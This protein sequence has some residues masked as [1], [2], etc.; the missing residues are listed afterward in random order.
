[1]KNTFA[2]LSAIALIT[3]AAFSSQASL[4][5]PDVAGSVTVIV[6][7]SANETVIAID[8]LGFPISIDA[9]GNT[10]DLE[11]EQTSPNFAFASA[12]A[13]DEGQFNLSTGAYGDAN[14]FST[15]VQTYELDTGNGGDFLFDFEIQRGSL[16]ASCTGGP[17]DITPID[18]EGERDNFEDFEI[19]RVQDF[20]AITEANPV[21]GFSFAESFYD[22]NISFTSA[23]DAN[24]N[25][26]LFDSSVRLT[27]DMDGSRVVESDS[28]IGSL[29]NN[30]QGLSGIQYNIQQQLKRIELDDLLANDTVTIVYEVNMS[31]SAVPDLAIFR[32]VEDDFPFFVNPTALAQFGDPSGIIGPNSPSTSLTRVSAP[33]N[34]LI[35]GLGVFALAFARK[36]SAK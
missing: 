5:T 14:A 20:S 12:N 6:A 34:L 21:C 30:I 28:V 33:G 1:M 29:S 36:R 10:V 24:L 19:A 4:I 2:K 13:N 7:P 31:S 11:T 27:S 18:V 26:S 32:N 15:I 25:R 22:I 16:F 17:L 9:T 3:S 23:L 8:S 35:L